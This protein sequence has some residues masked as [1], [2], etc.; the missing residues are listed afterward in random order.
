MTRRRLPAAVAA[1]S[2][3]AAI[4]PLSLHVSADAAG[5]HQARPTDTFGG[6]IIRVSTPRDA[7]RNRLEALGLDVLEGGGSNHLDVLVHT[8][9]ERSTL[10]AAGLRTR[11][12]TGDVAHRFAR[13]NAQDAAYAARVSTSRLP[14]GRTSYRT[15]RDYNSDIA[16]LARK[17]PRLAKA[18]VAPHKT[19]DDQLVHGIEIGSDVRRAPTGRPTFFLMGVHHAREWPS[20]ED[21][22]EFAF[23]LLRGYGHDPRITGLLDKARVLIVPI[24][25]VDGFDQS[26]TAGGALDLMP[27]DPFDPTGELSVVATPGEAYRRK[28]CRAVD[29]VDLGTTNCL[30][31][32]GQGGF[33]LGVDLNRNYAGFWGGPG[34][35]DTLPDPTSIGDVGLA[36]QDYHGTAPFSEPETRNVRDLVRAR[37]VT[38]L[39]SLHTSG[40]LVLRPNGVSPK[41]IGV[42]G[43]PVGDAADEAGL[44]R[45]G[46]RMAAADGFTSQHGWQ[47]YDT[48]GTTED[49]S[50][51]S[52]GG[53]GYTIEL[54]GTAFHQP[55][56]RVVRQYVGGTKDNPDGNRGAYLIALEHAVSRVYNGVLTGKAP[57]GAVLRL[58]KRFKTLTWEGTY[59]DHFSS[60]IKVPASGTFSWMVNPSTRPLSVSAGKRETYRLTC[61]VGGKVRQTMRVYVDRGE[62]KTVD[63]SGCRRN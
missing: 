54:G 34:A 30:V 24:V 60:W 4:V 48:T 15:M 1:I 3:L 26:R 46:D 62:T 16:M 63:L 42:D 40:D 20:G 37:Q 41:T 6:Q 23:D 25:N 7:V 38:M 8:E 18:L 39:I 56:E 10:E 11:V 31:A 35:A 44:K 32:A 59:P 19:L 9:L 33:G 14:S 29:G 51:N 57:A 28:N 17:Y 13:I 43:K 22:M 49:W 58:S 45:V 27:I 21:A 2:L 53:F 52:T 61:S 36:S 50:Y 12:V 47:L 55:F 5:Y